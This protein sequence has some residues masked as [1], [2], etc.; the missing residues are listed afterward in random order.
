[1]KCIWILFCHEHC[2]CKIGFL[3]P[4]RQWVRKSCQLFG[5]GLD[6]LSQQWGFTHILSNLYSGYLLSQIYFYI[7]GLKWHISTGC[8][9]WWFV[10]FL[11]VL[12]HRMK[13]GNHRACLLLHTWNPAH[14]NQTYMGPAHKKKFQE[15]QSWIYW[16]LL[17]WLRL[18]FKKISSNKPK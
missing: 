11:R 13:A 4:Q 10:L 7:Y 9:I 5:P 18:V 15:L 3:L 2:K 8:W 6:T 12:Q 16:R 17:L 14:W 1:M